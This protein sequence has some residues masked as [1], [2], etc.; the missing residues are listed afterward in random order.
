[1]FS[2]TWKHPTELVFG[3][4]SFDEA[5]DK[6]TLLGR[7][8]FIVTT[9]GGSME[10]F[11]WIPSLKKK[12]EEQGCEVMVYKGV[13]T[14]P[15]VEQIE[16]GVE[17]ARSFAAT[18]ILGIG[19]GSAID[20]AKAIAAVLASNKGV[21]DLLYGKAKIKGSLPIVA[22]P[23]TH[24][25]G[26]EVTRFSVISDLENHV[27]KSMVHPA[28]YPALSIV[29]PRLSKTLPAKLTAA[30]TVDALCHALESLA[31]KGRTRIGTVMASDAVGLIAR[32]ASKVMENPEDLDARTKLCWASTAA[33]YA[34]DTCRTTLLHAL[35]HGVSA[36]KPEVHHGVGLAALLPAWLDHAYPAAP[37]VLNEACSIIAG[38]PVKSKEEAVKAIEEF[39]EKLGL[40]V[41]LSELGVGED[42]LKPIAEHALEHMKPVAM[43]DPAPPRSI[44]EAVEI[45]RRAL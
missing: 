10:K 2:F 27:K 29:D 43:N 35:E 21:R 18:V 33:G 40:R 41:T 37:E 8:I 32:N 13:A 17:E 5:A 39:L 31:A 3:V 25:T 34:I 28:L 19:G 23:S 1:M 42:L 26:S 30:T 24:G 7:R 14:N 16:Q 45:L 15:T 36:Y 38:K 6:V 11:G 9:S 44:E 22:I 4:G 20:A 12:L